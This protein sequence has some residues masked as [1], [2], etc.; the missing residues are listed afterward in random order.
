MKGDVIVEAHNQQILIEEEEENKIQEEQ[1]IPLD[2]SQ[3]IQ[4]LYY[5]QNPSKVMS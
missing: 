5:N 4:Q 2:P 3:Q 1:E